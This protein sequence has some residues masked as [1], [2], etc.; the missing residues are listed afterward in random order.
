[1]WAKPTIPSLEVA[2]A[3]AV[4]DAKLVEPLDDRDPMQIAVLWNQQ[5]ACDHWKVPHFQCAHPGKSTQYT[6]VLATTATEGS[7]RRIAA[8]SPAVLVEVI[9]LMRSPAVPLNVYPSTSRPELS[10]AFSV[11]DPLTNGTSPPLTAVSIGIS[12]D[13]ASAEIALAEIR[14]ATIGA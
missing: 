10:A 13:D 4:K 12:F 2:D 14:P 5:G 9:K 7:R 11:W 8:S 1:M 3:C 6:R